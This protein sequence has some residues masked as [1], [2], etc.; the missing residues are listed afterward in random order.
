[1]LCSL[2]APIDCCLQAFPPQ[3]LFCRSVALSTMVDG[4]RLTGTLLVPPSL[5]LSLGRCCWPRWRTKLEGKLR[6]QRP[7]ISE[8]LP[9]SPLSQLDNHSSQT[10]SASSVISTTMLLM[11]ALLF[12]PRLHDTRGV[13][14]FGL[15][16]FLL[17]CCSLLKSAL[18]RNVY[19]V[20][21]ILESWLLPTSLSS[22]QS[23]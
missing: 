10:L 4:E 20:S 22:T 1:M 3:P 12:L 14:G 23:L 6:P 15:L 13:T 8:C 7:S 9:S 2:I 19:P 17:S 11:G 18:A 16:I 5:L 21:S